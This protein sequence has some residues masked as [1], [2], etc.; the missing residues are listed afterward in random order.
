MSVFRNKKTYSRPSVFNVR[1]LPEDVD[2]E[3]NAGPSETD[4]TKRHLTQE[5]QDKVDEE[6]RREA[7]RDLIESWM[8]RLQ[9]IS[10]ITTFFASTE[11]SLITPSTDGAPS[12]KTSQATHMGLMGA[13]VM[14]SN[15]AIMSFSAFFFLVR[16]KLKVASM[17]EAKTETDKYKQKALVESSTSITLEDVERGLQTKRRGKNW[18]HETDPVPGMIL[19]NSSFNQDSKPIFSS[20]P[21]LVQVGPFRGSP[22]IHLLGQC[23]SLCVVL[24]I[25]GFILDLMGILCYAWDRLP[26]SVAVS[27]SAFLTLYLISGLYI[28][29]EPEPKDGTSSF[30]YYSRHPHNP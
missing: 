25:I 6:K 23:H 9:L 18:E 1:T 26:L 2:S 17:E 27:S 20:N 11:A 29:T 10:V 19:M 5:D 3:K 24:T 21:H 28:W 30:M 15:A 13:L 16:Y 14:H 4:P 7:T 22:L 12:S 8:D